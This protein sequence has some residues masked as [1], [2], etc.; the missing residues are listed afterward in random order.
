MLKLLIPKLACPT[1]EQTE[2]PLIANVF[3]DL[4]GEHI[5]DGILICSAC[6]AWYPIEDELL[7]LV[8]TALIDREDLAA[9]VQR[10]SD[11]LIA[12]GVD[13]AK[14]IGAELPANLFEAQTKQRSHFDKYAEGHEP[15]FADYTLTPF[16]RAASERAYGV[17]RRRLKAS[18]SWILDVGC[19]TANSSLA[20]AKDHTV[21]GFDI[22]KK[23]IRRDIEAARNLGFTDTTFFVGDG[24]HPPLKDQS[25]DYVQTVGALHHLPDPACTINEI[26]RILVPG[27]IYF[28]SEN[29]RSMFRGIFDLLMKIHP[30]WIEEAGAEP[31]M[32]RRMF[33]DWCRGL[34]VTLTS[35]T[36]IF[37]PP[38]LVNLFPF[39]IA[40]RLVEWTDRVVLH[41]PIVRNHGGIIFVHI[42]KLPG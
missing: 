37:L 33:D 3:D 22:S 30:L 13:P 4:C 6:R 26:Q 7:E 16:I 42:T 28:A 29:N 31:T 32:S 34:P 1:C 39:N 5:R 20:F 24:A 17:W 14:A 15:G 40:R 38:H 35:E 8:T 2:A 18:R 9:F 41:I 27:G 25:F 10:F 12:C 36:S 23:M 21:V 19:G 11:Q